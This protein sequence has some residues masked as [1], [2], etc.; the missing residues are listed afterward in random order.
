MGLIAHRGFWG[1]NEEKNTLHAFERAFKNGYGVETDLRDY[2]EKLVVSHNIANENCVDVETFFQLYRECHSEALLALNVKADGI[3]VLLEPLLEKYDIANYFLFDMSIP[4][5][6]VN[7]N[8]NLHF[9]TRN[10]DI[11]KECV[12]Y[13]NAAGV[14]LDAF[15]DEH[16]LTEKIVMQHIAQ[17]MKVCIVSPE[18]HGYDPMRVW[19]ML[20]MTDLYKSDLVTLCTD[21][22]DRA[23]EYFNE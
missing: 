16:W 18:L 22:P 6:V 10:S 15:F 14:W 1:K 23:Q 5:L 2:R 8:R 11:E 12:L 13:D 3:Q 4:E 7:A 21:I 9:Y 17:G 19:E 20:R